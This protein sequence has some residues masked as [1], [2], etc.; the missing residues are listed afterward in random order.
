MNLKKI[1]KW[2][3]V[4]LAA[5]IILIALIPTIASSNWGR[6][7]IE[8]FINRSIAGN[9][10]IK[11]LN[12]SLFGPQHI[13][14]IVLKDPENQFVLSIEDLLIDLSLPQLAW[15]N[16]SKGNVHLQNLNLNLVE[17]E[18]GDSNVRQ[19]IRSPSANREP[20]SSL[21]SPI[22][23]HA[24]VL[25]LNFVPDSLMLKTR[26][27]TYQNELQGT[28]TI[29]AAFVGLNENN[30]KQLAESPELLMRSDTHFR[31]DTVIKNLP[32][33]LIDWAL[34]IKDPNLRGLAQHAIGNEL[35]L[36]VRNASGDNGFAFEIEASSA[37]LN[38]HLIADLS[39]DRIAI[40]KPGTVRVSIAPQLVQHFLP[41]SLDIQLGRPT[42]LL[43]AI[44]EFILPI[45]A[46][47]QA[48]DFGA[49]A[50][51]GRMDIREALLK[52]KSNFNDIL[53]DQMSAV[54]E[55]AS[56]SPQ[57]S[58][59][60]SGQASQNG[61][62]VQIGLET[63]LDKTKRINFR[64]PPP[65]K[66]DL[67]H[68][69]IALIDELLSLENTLQHHVGNYADL[70]LDTI[71][72][73]ESMDLAIEFRSE[74]VSIPSL[75]VNIGNDVTLIEPM[76]VYYDMDGQTFGQIQLP[77]QALKLQAMVSPIKN[78]QN[79]HNLSQVNL[80]GTF[81][82]DDITIQTSQFKEA[83]H[84]QNLKLPWFVKA[85]E[86][87]A[88]I[89]VHGDISDGKIALGS[90][91][92]MATLSN[93]L[94]QDKPDLSKSFVNA[95][96]EL[97]KI[98]ND[99]IATLSKDNELIRLIGPFLDAKI[100]GTF[101][102]E[103]RKGNATIS[104][105][106]D[107]LQG[108]GQIN[109]A[110]DALQISPFKI[111]LKITPERF[112]AVRKFMRGE[113]QDHL[114]LADPINI[115]M[116]VEGKLAKSLNEAS[117]SIHAT[118]DHLVVVDTITGHSLTFENIQAEA[119]AIDLYKK[120]DFTVTAK[121]K[122]VGQTSDFL[123]K[124][125]I[126]D[127]FLPTG[128]FNR[129]QLSMLLDVRI[130]ELPLNLFC[131]TFCVDKTID[132]KIEALFGPALNVDVHTALKQGNGPLQAALKGSNGQ[133]N[134]DA[135]IHD[136][137]LYLNQ[138]FQASF[139]ATKALGHSILQD[140]FPLLSGTVSADQPFKIT[141]D[142]SGFVVP[143][144]N[145]DLSGIQI[146]RG[147]LSLGNVKFTKDGQLGEILSLLTPPDA[148]LIAVWFTPLYF[149]MNH[150]ELN[151]SRIDMLISNHFPIAAWG[152]VNFPKD[153]I[154]MA[155]GLSGDAISYAFNVDVDSAYMLQLPLKGKIASPSL[156]K[157]R[158]TTKIGALVAH[159]QKSAKGSIIGTVLD[160]ASGGL[161]EEKPPR[162]T[163]QPF[164]WEKQM[165][166]DRKKRVKEQSKVEGAP[167]EPA[168]KEKSND[169]I[170]K[171]A[172]SLIDNLFR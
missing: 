169:L 137:L 104:F 29:D 113:K 164:P 2:L 143:V 38:A 114:S 135:R 163:T 67:K 148:D 78:F 128:A 15:K 33:A 156:D 136:G 126:E 16:F 19:A 133:V 140:I 129:D 90:I 111:N 6:T 102:N 27:T 89:Q 171:A 158:A 74:K 172:N 123:A 23:F 42:N 55:T 162:P 12:L 145:F 7:Q 70:T 48:Y 54:V 9:I 144:R 141:I 151:L 61:K 10:S 95:K 60:V 83:M 170:E 107:E 13:E 18:R 153:K 69:P 52:S 86:N 150:G 84:V 34:A 116:K 157:S 112:T 17:G 56:D 5:L 77:P 94:S 127:A 122:S 53:L 152:T 14:T 146:S 8:N 44:E 96:L 75:L 108:K 24:E 41:P 21:G 87:R 110:P 40:T 101:S 76:T 139:T 106:G 121:Q 154:Q 115:T 72:Q 62:P 49:F 167:V 97:T 3:F 93:W 155:I 35:N 168:K 32:V 160:L 134:F 68:I 73:R 103:E 22:Y 99:L 142:S 159:S 4:F 98:S 30:V 149:S 28:F 1:F 79:I 36:N 80:S 45:D 131:D 66:L 59:K 11:N 124:G 58:L 50:L 125:V 31:I 43:I 64:L 39:A 51:K 20:F 92:N 105:V 71:L 132:Q 166:A 26:G 117:V 91:Y 165:E 147:T 47:R 82:I 161:T 119:Q 85:A 109:F 120:L 130:S 37:N 63:S 138:P 81:D 100:D 25:S 88:Q 46:K 118:T 65:M 57:L